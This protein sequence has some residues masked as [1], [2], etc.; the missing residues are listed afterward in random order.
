MREKSEIDELFFRLMGYY[1]AKAGQAY[2]MISA[3]A[4]GI[5][6]AHI[7]EHNKFMKGG[8]KPP[9]VVLQSRM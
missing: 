6:K 3:A 8:M 5:V 1:P 7:A 4:L 2:E 9:S